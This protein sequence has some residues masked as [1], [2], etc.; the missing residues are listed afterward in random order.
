[1]KNS[2]KSLFAI[3][4]CCTLTGCITDINV[5]DL[6]TE[7][8]GGTALA[9]PIGSVH[10]N[11]SDLLD[12]V[13]STYITADSTNAICILYS[14]NDIPLDLEFDNIEK[15]ETLKD[16]IKLK[17]KECFYEI[18]NNLPS[19]ITSVTLPAGSYKFKEE[20]AYEFNFDE[21]EDNVKKIRID[22]AII[23]NAILNLTLNTYNVSLSESNY[24]LISVKYPEILDERY[25]SEFQN[26][27]ITTN[28]Y[29]FS[30]ELEHLRILF[31]KMN[32][33]D[34]IDLAVDF[35]LVSDGT[36]QITRESDLQF[37]MK[38][39]ILNSEALFGYIWMK[40]PI[41]SDNLSY[42]IPREV[43][44]NELLKNSNLLFTNP[45]LELNAT[46]NIGVPLRLDIHDVY[47]VKEGEEYHA[48][49]N[50]NSSLN[51]EI[52]RPAQPYDSASTKLILDRDNGSLHTLLSVLPEQ[53]NINYSVSTIYQEIENSWHFLTMPILANVDIMAKVP[54]Q[55]DPTSNFIY[56]DTIDAD[57][58]SLIE[59]GTLENI[60]IDTVNLYLDIANRL[61]VNTNLK[62]V[63]LDEN[64]QII[65]ESKTFSIKSA[66]VN[67]EGR[68]TN[69]TK[70]TIILST[71]GE[72]INDVLNTKK[73]ILAL[74]LESYDENSRIYF[75]TTDAI[76][77]RL[78]AFIKVRASIS[79]DEGVEDEEYN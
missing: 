11:M 77:I 25:A 62:L 5:S 12:L 75:Q 70:E 19:N 35:E 76:D 78:S 37:N 8:N 16:T 73:I 45:I 43:I 66:E 6:N 50:N 40:E 22:S 29:S 33:N 21:E 26:I 13:D 27:K 47:A 4:L 53:I 20:S 54:L 51:I 58:S 23:E 32:E 42:D 1:M 17:N 59:D 34:S 63:Y 44:E 39:D 65:T 28:E 7:V 64:D 9:V 14:Q 48:T 49:F 71:N 30:K 69:E 38:V 10:A 2:F 57:L 79:L 46:T 60:E 41:T 72:S 36:L 56:N 3:L 68:V 24:L 18:L 15:S 67:I 52:N 55:F 31:T 74:S 61:P